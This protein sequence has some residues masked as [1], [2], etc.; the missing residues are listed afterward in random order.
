MNDSPPADTTC[1]LFIARHFRAPVEK[2][3]RHFTNL[4]SLKQ[5]LC[6]EPCQVL[7]GAFD[8]RVGGQYDLQISTGEYGQIGLKGE[9]LEIIPNEKIAYTFQWYG[10]PEFSGIETRVSFTF[11]EEN[12]GTTLHML[13]AGLADAATR[14]NHH[15]GWNGSFDRLL[16]VTQMHRPGRINWNELFTRD[17]Q[18]SKAFYTAL[19]GWETVEMPIAGTDK[20]YTMFSDGCLPLAGVVE[21]TPECGDGNVPTHWGSYISVESVEE[22]LTKAKEL[23]ASVVLPATDIGNM[24][25]MAV[26]ADPQG[27]TIAFWK[28]NC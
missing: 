4:E 21:V 5:W 22:T 27:G 13:H 11:K 19:M 10:H 6:P 9:Y 25:T 20:T 15:E 23:G 14:D 8:F 28:G 1:D 12:G 16:F 2:V 7:D 3:Y 18:A 24:G 17:P 26:I